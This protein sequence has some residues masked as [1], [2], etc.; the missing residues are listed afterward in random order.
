MSDF[1]VETYAIGLDIGGTHLRGG[2]VELA[3]G[4]IV[5]K[6]IIPTE[7]KRGGEAV[8]ADARRLVE[9]LMAEAVK[10]GVNIVGIG[11]G[12][13][14][15][16]DPEGDVTSSH[17]VVWDGMPIRETFSRL[18]PCVV[19]S[20]VRAAALAEA[21]FGAGRPFKIVAYITV[22]TGISCCLVQSGKVYAGARGN[23]L[24]L[25][26]S[27]LTAICSAC[28]TRYQTV[29]GDVAA[30]PALAARYNRV[31]R[32]RVSGGEEVMA[33]ADQGDAAAI[34]VVQTAGE[35]LGVSSEGVWGWPG[36][37]FTGP[38][39]F[40]PPDLIFGRTDNTRALPI[41]PAE[42]GPDVGLVGAAMATG[43]RLF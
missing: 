38:A 9:A 24:I 30:G 17:A 23:A 25:A 1:P 18:A 34:E 22:G 29:L 27:P 7:P 12:V 16:V 35:A 28:G 40:R 4:R 10:L 32:G 37:G 6:R 26:G 36:G 21:R 43:Q 13:C 14:E 41:L 15:L 2:I 42:L 8:L 3:S 11:L 31:R 5:T 33:A 39:L 19:E 20:D